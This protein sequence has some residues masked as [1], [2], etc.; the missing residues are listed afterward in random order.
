[1]KQGPIIILVKTKLGAICGGFRS[2]YLYGGYGTS[3]K[4][5]SAFVFNL[6]E[7]FIPSNNNSAIIDSNH[8]FGFGNG[9]LAVWGDQL[10]ADNNGYCRVGTDR[11]Y[12]ISGD[13]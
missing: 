2:K 13:S 7:K 10:N 4:D 12:N 11:Y 5:D 1:L 3:A 9:I 6:N 8:G